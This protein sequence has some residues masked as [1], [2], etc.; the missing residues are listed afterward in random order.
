MSTAKQ[1]AD[2]TLAL[3]EDR[4]RRVDYALHGSTP[5]HPADAASQDIKPGDSA[6]T[7]LRSLERASSHLTARSS[8]V[9]EVLAL[10]K[11]HPEI[12]NPS[13]A[14]PATW[15]QEHVL[16]IVLAHAALYTTISH[17]LTN[18]QETYSPNSAS[19]KDAVPDPAQLATLIELLPRIEKA[20]EKQARLSRQIA[21]LR[22]RSAAVVEDWV[23]G[24]VLGMGGRWAEWEGRLAGCERVIRRKEAALRREREVI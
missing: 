4:L 3:L 14:S 7:R 21:E 10:Q 20:A 18:L 1:T 19:L 5:G 16:A 8:T 17:Y 15:P 23:E 22:A 2:Q 13:S 11:L 24:G 9:A 12:F 6:I